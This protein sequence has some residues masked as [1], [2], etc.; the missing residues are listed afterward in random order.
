MRLEASHCGAARR[1]RPRSRFSL[2]TGPDWMG[3][4]KSF[5]AEVC[6]FPRERRGAAQDAIARA[7][8]LGRRRKGPRPR[9]R[10]CSPR[11][12][13]PGPPSC[14]LR[15]VGGL[16]CHTMSRA[17]SAPQCQ[18]PPEP[19]CFDLSLSRLLP[20]HT[21]GNIQAAGALHARLRLQPGFSAPTRGAQAKSSV[22]ASHKPK[23]RSMP[24]PP[25]AFGRGY[26]FI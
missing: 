3:R 11:C 25:N 14:R 13:C 10:E 19:P 9:R 22:P 12:L 2:Q 15:F 6:P 24:L 7:V 21:Q 26:L 18:G 16:G 23:T 17:S 8:L 5:M 20:V 1:G 4:D